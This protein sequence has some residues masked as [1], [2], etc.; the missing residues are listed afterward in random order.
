MLVLRTSQPDAYVD[1]ER[2]EQED[3]NES[4][5]SLQVRIPY[6]GCEAR[7]FAGAI[8]QV[9]GEELRRRELGKGCLGHDELF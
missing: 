1:R 8:R 4:D 3:S 6:K 7:R 2:D 5:H 9:L